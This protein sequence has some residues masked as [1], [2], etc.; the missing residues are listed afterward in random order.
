MQKKETPRIA[1]DQARYLDNHTYIYTYIDSLS[2]VS[3]TTKD[4]EGISGLL[5]AN[6]SRLRRD[7]LGRYRRRELFFVFVN[8]HRSLSLAR[9]YYDVINFSSQSDP[10]YNTQY[11][12]V[13]RVRRLVVCVQG[14]R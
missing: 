14:T 9:L 10:V 1:C 6:Q 2:Y 13:S 7:R 12:A 3:F 5:S 4:T 8:T 11:N